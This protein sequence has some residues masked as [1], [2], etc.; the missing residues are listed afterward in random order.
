MKLQTQRSGQ[1]LGH[2]ECLWRGLWG[3][4]QHSACKILCKLA[5]F[6]LRGN[7]SVALGLDVFTL[8]VYKH[9]F[10]NFFMVSQKSWFT[11]FKWAHFFH[12][13]GLT[14]WQNKMSHSWSLSGGGGINKEVGINID[15][16][17]YTYMYNRYSVRTYWTTCGTLLSTL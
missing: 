3:H 6:N 2:P 12:F 17:I 14:L 10:L 13:S 4:I 1:V 5:W 16:Q 8:M 9:C 11:G 7:R 15:T